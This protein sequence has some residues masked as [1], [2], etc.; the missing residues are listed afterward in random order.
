MFKFGGTLLFPYLILAFLLDNIPN[1]MRFIL[2]F[3]LTEPLNP[4]LF[5]GVGMIVIGAILSQIKWRTGE[6][7]SGSDQLSITGAKELQ[8]PYDSILKTYTI[9]SNSQQLR[10]DS[11]CYDITIIFNSTAERNQIRERTEKEI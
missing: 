10:I 7:T 4:L 6:L 5:T 1:G 2:H 8:I 11:K 9:E 3:K